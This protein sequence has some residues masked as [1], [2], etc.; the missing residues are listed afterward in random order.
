M[1]YVGRRCLDK[2]FLEVTRSAPKESLTEY[3]NSKY[4]KEWIDH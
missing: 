1:N 2:S 4:E 3:R